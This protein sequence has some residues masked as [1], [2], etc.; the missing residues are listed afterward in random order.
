MF[1]KETGSAHISE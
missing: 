1:E